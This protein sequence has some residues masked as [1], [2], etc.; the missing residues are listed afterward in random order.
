MKHILTFICIV[1]CLS[2][3]LFAQKGENT[4][5][6]KAVKI[7]ESAAEPYWGKY[8][9]TG[10]TVDERMILRAQK[11]YEL[12]LLREE[13]QFVVKP[14]GIDYQ[15]AGNFDIENVPGGTMFCMCASASDDCQITVTME[16]N[17][18]HYFCDGSCGC[19]SFTVWDVQKDYPE[20][21]SMNGDWRPFDK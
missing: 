11:G 18:I 12:L 6:V 7:S 21:Q 2:S 17:S 3:S 1:F 19:G 15:E 4:V 5:V 20:Y 8:V 9:V 16:G 13:N 10:F 14:V